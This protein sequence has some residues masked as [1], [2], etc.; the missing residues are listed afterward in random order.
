M[1]KS[2]TIRQQLR[3]ELYKQFEAGKGQSRHQDK[4]NRGQ[5][6]IYDKI[7]SNNS[8]H[9]HI[10]RA[11]QFANWV[12]ETHPEIRKIKDITHDI[13]GEYLKHQQNGRNLSAWTIS[14]DLG[15]IN[16]ILIAQ[17]HW[18]KPIVKRDYGL[19][20][21]RQD[22]VR[23]NRAANEYQKQMYDKHLEKYERE[24]YYGQAF[25]LRRSELLSNRAQ[26]TVAS[27]KS[28]YERNGQ[29][30]HVTTGKGGR[31][32]VIECLERHRDRII[33]DYGQ[34]IQPLPGYLQKDILGVEE[35]K[36]FLEDYKGAKKFFKTIDRN[37]RIH[38]NCRQFFANQKLKE[39]QSQQRFQDEND[40]IIKVNGKEIYKSEAEFISKQLG[41][42]RIDVLQNYVSRK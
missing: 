27:S 29:L 6:A 12:K 7:Y 2:K 20:S 22:E 1:G 21:R 8:L 14:A 34:Y 9:T 3:M 11:D 25:G 35:R 18:D 5:H 42:N 40:E 24:I 4:I 41:H 33:A 19:H 39:I 38:V 36:Q 32:R 17:G 13:A 37:V 26:H 16:R 31:L 28:L 15:M 23:H 10:S 30:Y